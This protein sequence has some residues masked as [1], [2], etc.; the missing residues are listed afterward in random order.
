MSCSAASS[1]TRSGPSRTPVPNPKSEARKRRAE[2]PI[3][4]RPNGDAIMRWRW[5]GLCCCV[6]VAAGCGQKAPENGPPKP[7]EVEVSYPV[8][9]EVTDYEEF[10]GRTDAVKMVEV[11]ARATGYLNKINFEDGDVVEKDQ[12]LFEIDPGTYAPEYKRAEAAVEQA[13]A[14]RNRLLLDLKRAQQLVKDKSISQEEFDKVNGDVEEAKA[15]VDVAERA[16]DLAK[17]NLDYT[18]VKAPIA[19]K[20]GRRFVDPG[21][22]IKADDTLLTTIVSQGQ[23]YAYFDV[24]ERTVLRLRRL[25]K[26]GKLSSI[27]DNPIELGLAD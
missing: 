19:G 3:S 12:V 22:L 2:R 8:R 1:P 4:I 27:K 20:I 15:A 13:V 11:R 25:I 18:K 23:L 6:G 16:R 21:N 9:K 14:R 5:L 10:T 17:V 24:D 26:D 7:P